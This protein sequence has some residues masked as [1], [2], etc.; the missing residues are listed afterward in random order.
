VKGA[1]STLLLLLNFLSLVLLA[2]LLL[3]LLHA[4]TDFLVGVVAAAATPCMHQIFTFAAGWFNAAP[5]RT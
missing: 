3:L 1:L 2:L 4:V 5:S